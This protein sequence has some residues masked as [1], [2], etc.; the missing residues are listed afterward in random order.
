MCIRDRAYAAR[1]PS[2]LLQPI[3]ENAIKYAIA[4]REDGGH[5]RIVVTLSDDCLNIIV[6][7]NGPGLASTSQQVPKVSGTGLGLEN[8]RSRLEALYGTRQSVSVNDISGG[9]GVQVHLQMPFQA[10]ANC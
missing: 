8:I 10:L 6:R 9:G 1:I 2:L 5:I 3:I 7:D 4:P